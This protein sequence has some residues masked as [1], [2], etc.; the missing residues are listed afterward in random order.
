[1]E[2]TMPGFFVLHSLLD[3]AQIHILMLSNC[4]ILCHPLLLLPSIFPSIR[5]FSKES[6]LC[7]RWPKYW[8]FSFSIVLPVNIKGWF[9]LGLTG[10]ILDI[11]SQTRTDLYGA[12][13]LLI[14][15]RVPF[16]GNGG[17][18]S[19]KNSASLPSHQRIPFLFFQASELG[20]LC[21]MK[22]FIHE[23]FCHSH[24]WHFYQNGLYYFS[25]FKLEVASFFRT[26]GKEIG[27]GL[28]LIV[29]KILLILYHLRIGRDFLGHEMHWP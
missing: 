1:M 20:N 10:F 18:V 25:N 3:F 15:S 27:I 19:L 4:L 29:F 5:V 11:K 23:I 24:S 16:G 28:F 21:G 14:I 6:V 12:P 8:R 9:P 17:G 2:C 22:H 13:K 26:K 7:I